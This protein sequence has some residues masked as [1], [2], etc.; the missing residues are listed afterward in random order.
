MTEKSHEPILVVD[1]DD[2]TRELVRNL[3]EADGY[4]VIEAKNGKAALD[5]LVSK[6]TT[7][8]CLILLD[9]EMPIMSGWE[10]L[11]IVKSYARLARIPV[12]IVSGT[13]PHAETL[14]RQAVAAW[15]RKPCPPE[16]LASIV[17]E[18]A[19]KHCG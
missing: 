5:A 2:D 1:D 17:E 15:I 10:F 14:A 13:E 9:L 19:H 16:Q 4:V 7:E 3:L 12:V 8:P 6:P 18:H 11:A